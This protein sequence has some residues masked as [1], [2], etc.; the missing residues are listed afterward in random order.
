[1]AKTI[2]QTKEE[3]EIIELELNQQFVERIKKFENE[4]GVSLEVTF[5]GETEKPF[6]CKFIGSSKRYEK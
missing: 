2:L 5:T 6:S 1:M 3:I 4:F